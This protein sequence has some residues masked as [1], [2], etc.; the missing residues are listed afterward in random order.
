[1]KVRACKPST[2]TAKAGE[3]AWAIYWDLVSEENN[4]NKNRPYL[5]KQ[6]KCMIESGKYV[7]KL[8]YNYT[9]VILNMY[10]VIIKG[11]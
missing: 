9:K 1:M 10:Y 3:S 4:K 6:N 5:G 7:S 2:Q 11:F 8:L